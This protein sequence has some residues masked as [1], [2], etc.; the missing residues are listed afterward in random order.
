MLA[1][2]LICLVSSLPGR[3]L[4]PSLRS[5]TLPHCVVEGR[6]RGSLRLH[7]AVGEARTGNRP[8]AEGAVFAGRPERLARVVRFDAFGEF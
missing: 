8:D 7:H 2:G 4:P 6:R 3:P 5:G 1:A